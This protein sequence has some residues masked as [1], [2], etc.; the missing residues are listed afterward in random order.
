[1]SAAIDA[2]QKSVQKNA[3]ATDELSRAAVETGAAMQE[4]DTSISG[5]ERQALATADL[6]HEMR[7]NADRGNTA[8]SRTVEGME[9]IKSSA[10]EAG[11]SIRALG[12]RI[13]DIG[14]ILT[15]IQEVAAQT[16][17]LALNASIIASQAG[18]HGR[19]FAVVADEIKNLAQ[20]TGRSTQEI[21]GL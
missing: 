12:G 8:V 6:S 16:N 1:A 21:G 18:S 11:A 15:V 3:A 14:A 19:G 2:M 17:L 4:L 10:A 7:D 20:R 9:L 13:G 5:V